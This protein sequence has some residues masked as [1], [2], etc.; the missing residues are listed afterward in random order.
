MLTLEGRD[1]DL[2]EEGDLGE[3]ETC[4]AVLLAVHTQGGDLLGY[5]NI[6]EVRSVLIEFYK[7]SLCALRH[8]RKQLWS[9]I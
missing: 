1:D 2:L 4:R 9:L 7:S 6:H 8:I 3:Q 5:S